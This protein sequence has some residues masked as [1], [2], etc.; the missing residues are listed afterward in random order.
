MT[1]EFDAKKSYLTVKSS[2]KVLIEQQLIPAIEKLLPCTF[3]PV[4]WWPEGI[5]TQT[6]AQEEI[7]GHISLRG[8]FRKWFGT[9]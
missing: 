9:G 4:E 8:L 6:P 3:D 7:E 1:E 5:D 2:E